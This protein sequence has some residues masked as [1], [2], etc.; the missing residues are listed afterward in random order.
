MVYCTKCGTNNSEDANNCT[1]CGAALYKEGPRPY[2]HNEYR[3]YHYPHEH[4]GSGIGLL[5]AGLFIILLGN[6]LLFGLNIWRFIWPL[7]I[8]LVGIWIIMWV[9]RHN[10][11]YTQASP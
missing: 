9:L 3:H 5:I 1:N 2:T 11:R 7:I 4:R 6:A 8:V 10:R